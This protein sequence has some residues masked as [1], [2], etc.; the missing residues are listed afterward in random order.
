ML[1]ADGNI[2]VR[3]FDPVE[4][5]TGE[6]VNEW[7]LLDHGWRTPGARPDPRGGLRI[8]HI[9]TDFVWGTEQDEFEVDYIVRYRL[10]KGL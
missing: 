7:W 6:A 10:V 1:D 8:R 3:R 2:W 4:L 5:D 9:G